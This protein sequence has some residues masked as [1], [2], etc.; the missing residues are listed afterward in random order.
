MSCSKLEQAAPLGRRQEAASSGA[1]L[2]RSGQPAAGGS[3]RGRGNRIERHSSGVGGSEVCRRLAAA[4]LFRGTCL[5]VFALGVCV[6]LSASR[7]LSALLPQA[8]GA[9]AQGLTDPEPST[10]HF[11]L[12]D[13]LEPGVDMTT[14]ASWPALAPPRGKVRQMIYLCVCLVLQGHAAQ[15]LAVEGERGPG[16]VIWG[17]DHPGKGQERGRGKPGATSL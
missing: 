4:E 17:S 6:C 8:A 5:S 10:R 11:L 12:Q 2:Q 14:L 15:R 7:L 16:A 13:K 9:H 3:S 1:C